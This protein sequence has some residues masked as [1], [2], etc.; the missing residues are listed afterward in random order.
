MKL[1]MESTTLSDG[2]VLKMTYEL[3]PPEHHQRNL[4]KKLIATF[5]DHFIG[6]LSCC[7]KSMPM[8][9]WCQLLPQVEWQLLLLRQSQVNPGMSTYAHVYQGQHDYN[10]HPFVPIGR[11]LLVHVKPH[12]RQ[13]YAQH[14][15]KGYVIGTSCRAHGNNLYGYGG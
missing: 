5:K 2:S 8:H 13:T 10:K 3:V 9:L 6:V 11:E 7:A 1:A 15:N 12:K 14:C 4:A